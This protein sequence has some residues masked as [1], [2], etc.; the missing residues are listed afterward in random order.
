MAGVRALARDGFVTKLTAAKQCGANRYCNA[1]RAGGAPGP[2]CRGCD[3]IANAVAMVSRS[4][5]LHAA[6]RLAAL[7]AVER[8]A[9]YHRASAYTAPFVV[10]PE[11]AR[12]TNGLVFDAFSLLDAHGY[13]AGGDRCLA[14]AMVKLLALVRAYEGR[15]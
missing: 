13:V 14:D 3:A 4:N 11:D 1:L 10:E 5:A 7:E 6:E 12:F 15:Q 2:L 8:T 9:L